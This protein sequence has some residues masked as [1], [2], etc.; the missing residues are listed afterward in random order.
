L[1]EEVG[2]D[3]IVRYEEIDA[4]IKHGKHSKAS[5]LRTSVMFS[6]KNNIHPHARDSLRAQEA[7]ELEWHSG[8]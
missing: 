6:S 8:S 2:G 3:G 1:H 4:S 7:Q 5:Y